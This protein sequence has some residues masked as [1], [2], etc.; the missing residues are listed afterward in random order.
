MV[1]IQILRD[2]SIALLRLCAVL[3]RGVAGFLAGTSWAH[4]QARIGQCLL[5]MNAKKAL[6]LS[7]QRLL[8]GRHKP[9]GGPLK[10]AIKPRYA[11]WARGPKSASS[12]P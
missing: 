8:A 2:H 1:I 4:A 7:L 3:S 11:P 5:E 10:L 12:R 6:Q 9:L